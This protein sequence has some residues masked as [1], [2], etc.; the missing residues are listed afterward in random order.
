VEAAMNKLYEMIRTYYNGDI[1]EPVRRRINRMLPLLNERQ[2]RLYLACEAQAIGSGG[3]AEVSRITGFSPDTIAKGLKELDSEDTALEVGKSRKLRSKKKSIKERYP[4][5]LADLNRIIENEQ[6]RKGNILHYTDKSAESISASLKQKGLNVSASVIGNLLKEQGYNLRKSKMKMGTQGGPEVEKQFM[7]INKKARS[8][9]KRGE[10]ALVIE[11]KEFDRSR[12]KEAAAGMVYDRQYLADRLGTGDPLAYYELFRNKGFVNTGL[13]GDIA[14]IAIE[15]LGKWCETERFER[16]RGTE[17]M[18]L[19]ADFCGD[20]VAWA[21]QLRSLADRLQK[22]ITALHFPPGIT[23][24]DKVEHR[25]Y[26]FITGDQG[27]IRGMVIIDLIG[28]GENTGS[29]VEC[30]MD[31]GNDPQGTPAG[32]GRGQFHGE[33]N[34][35]IMPRARRNRQKAEALG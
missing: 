10:A 22:K 15:C 16:Y 7:R 33:W 23:R 21:P 28:T 35:T 8:C 24:W 25:L 34:Y 9:L 32:D 6:A 26:S 11:A 20:S 14:R 2:R 3:I 13:S 18:L 12:C 17:R 27:L 19:V 5:I 30:V 29:T 4:D 1:Y 31:A